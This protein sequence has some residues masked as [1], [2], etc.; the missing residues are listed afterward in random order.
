VNTYATSDGTVT[1]DPELGGVVGVLS[2]AFD[3]SPTGAATYSVPIEVLPGIQGMQP[4]LSLIYNSQSGNG[5]A[6]MC[7]NLGG[8]SMISRVPRDYYHDSYRSGIIWDSISPLALDGQR[9]IKINRW[10]SDSIEYCTESGLERIVGYTI[11]QWG[12]LTFKVYTKEGQILE[13]GNTSMVHSYLPVRMNSAGIST[14]TSVNHL[15]WALT[16]IMDVNNNYVDFSYIADQNNSSGF[17]Y[18]K[19]VRVSSISYGNHTGGAKETVGK[20]DFVY[21]HRTDSST[22]AYIDGLEMS[23]KYMLKKIQIKGMNDLLKDTYELSYESHDKNDFLKQ[24][25]K[26]NASGEFILPLQ[27]EWRPMNYT[28]SDTT[29]MTFALT[30]SPS[31]MTF[32]TNQGYSIDRFYKIYG[33][34]NGDGLTDVIAKVRYTKNS[35]HQYYWMEFIKA[36]GENELEAI[37][38]RDPL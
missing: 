33:D 5:M 21:T 3:V 9:L 38:K 16:R 17:Y 26:V 4:N 6:G 35:N 25:K 36:E 18:Y 19:N 28:I 31:Y 29:K 12:P 14:A 23:N 32:C 13:Y 11:K 27:F 20:V 30:Q 10:G 37:A 1:P 34:I 8:L 7:W 15:G 22:V 2:S 24:I